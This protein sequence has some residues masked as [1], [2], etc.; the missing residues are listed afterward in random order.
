MNF[1]PNWRQGGGGGP[2][3]GPPGLGFFKKSVET[4]I[5]DFLINDV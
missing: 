5:I 3:R 1:W 4:M 2:N